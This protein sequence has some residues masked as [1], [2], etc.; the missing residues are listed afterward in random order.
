MPES[1]ALAI[2][3]TGLSALSSLSSAYKNFREG[4]ERSAVSEISEA[5]YTAR[6]EL[7]RLQSDNESLATEIRKLKDKSKVQEQLVVEGGV[8]YQVVDGKK[9]VPFCTLCW[10]DQQKLIR[11]QF[12]T[13][14]RHYCSLHKQS[15]ANPGKEVSAFGGFSGGPSVFDKEF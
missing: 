14:N 12:D 10:D 4:K 3:T 11:T 9:D 8:Y 1:D 13:N 5:L 6:T 15:F 2:I 7:L